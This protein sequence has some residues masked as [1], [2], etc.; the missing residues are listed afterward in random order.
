[1]TAHPIPVRLVSLHVYPVKSCHR[2]DLTTATVGARG[3]VGDREWMVVAPDGRFLT[4]RT[5]PLLASVRPERRDGLLR[6]HCRDLAPLELPADGDDAW[7]R[8]RVRIWSDEVEAA[9]AGAQAREWLHAA[10][11]VEAELVRSGDYT[12]RQ[13]AGPWTAGRD[14]PVAFPDGYPLLVC[15]AASLEDLNAR[16]PAPLPMTRFRPNL[17][18]EGLSAHEEDAVE[19]LRFG[20]CELR[21]VKPCTR[22]ST[23]AVDQE[24][25]VPAA[26]PLEALKA[27][28]WDRALRGVTFGQNAVIEA[29]RGL[30]LEAGMTGV[31]RRRGDG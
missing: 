17:V 21:L 29:G 15:N 8:R 22:C 28:R 6:L 5:H 13:P 7:P 20:D 11:G 2:L 1:M 30:R 19:A 4:Q 27:Y 10:L 12:L 18:V 24:R 26:S 23:T 16:L 14:V 31:A 3:L 9:S 25:G